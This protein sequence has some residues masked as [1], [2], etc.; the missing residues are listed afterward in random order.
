ST[1]V[2][3]RSC[4][5]SRRISPGATA[6]SGCHPGVRSLAMIVDHLLYYDLR[7]AS[8]VNASVR[9]LRQRVMVRLEDQ[10]VRAPQVYR[11]LAGPVR[12][13]LMTVA[14]HTVH[15]L[16]GGRT[17]QRRQAPLE[18]RPVLRAPAHHTL[19]VAGDGLLQPAVGPRDLDRPPSL[20]SSPLGLRLL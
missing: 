20:T 6:Q 3:P 1:W 2:M 13:Q 5:A 11:E 19:A 9:K 17:R 7:H 15:V 14:G 16:Q 8:P 18:T 12:T 10:P 4:N